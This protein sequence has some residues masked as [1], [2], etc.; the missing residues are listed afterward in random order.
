MSIKTAEQKTPKSLIH[1]IVDE[2][3]DNTSFEE[4]LRELAFERMVERGLDDS[5]SGRIAS[6]DEA[7]RRIKSWE[8]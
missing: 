3:P 4:I 7:L 5:R 1:S 6:E 2:Q 8:R